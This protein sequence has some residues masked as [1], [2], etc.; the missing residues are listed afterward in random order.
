LE[1]LVSGLLRPKLFPFGK[2]SKAK[3]AAHL[4]FLLYL[5]LWEVEAL[6]MLAGREGDDKWQRKQKRRGRLYVFLLQVPE[7]G[8][9]N[10]KETKP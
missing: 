5:S 1:E 8:L 4:V 2:L 9:N 7:H 3:P 6:S 10:Y